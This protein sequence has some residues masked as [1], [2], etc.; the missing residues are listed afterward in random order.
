MKE[1]MKGIDLSLWQTKNFDF[2]KAKAE[3]YSCPGPYL[4]SKMDYICDEVNKR[5]KKDTSKGYLTGVNVTRT[6][7]ALVMYHAP[8][9]EA[10][11]NKWGTEIAYDSHGVAICNPI[12]GK[13]HMAIL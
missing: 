13:G 6:T 11:T 5:L 1:I 4:L 9:V 8:F 7:Y 10:P 3:G 2:I 12:N